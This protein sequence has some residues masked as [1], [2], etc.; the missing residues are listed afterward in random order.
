[1]LINLPKNYV[2]IGRDLALSTDH[3]RLY[4][5]YYDIF[6]TNPIR[7]LNSREIYFVQLMKEVKY[8]PATILEAKLRDYGISNEE[9]L[10]NPSIL[11]KHLANLTEHEYTTLAK[12]YNYLI[13]PAINYGNVRAPILRPIN[14]SDMILI[15]SNIAAGISTVS[16]EQ[17]TANTK[18]S[19]ISKLLDIYENH[20]DS[21]KDKSKEITEEIRQSASNMSPEQLKLVMEMASSGKPLPATKEANRKPNTKRKKKAKPKTT[22]DSTSDKPKTT[23]TKS[24]SKSSTA[25]PKS[26]T[27]KPKS[28]TKQKEE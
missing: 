26:S 3:V 2:T 21:V 14:H 18:V 28:E 7:D 12:Y 20:K 16:N 24:K 19:A 6:K 27:A 15:L 11:L 9:Y 5:E 13:E 17:I 4:F 1:M 25:K 23:S 22:A 8:Y 10:T